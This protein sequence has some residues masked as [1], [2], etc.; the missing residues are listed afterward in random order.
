MSFIH[1]KKQRIQRPE[2]PVEVY[3]VP[4]V[5]LMSGQKKILIPNPAGSE[6]CVYPTLE[7][8]EE[9]V[10]RAGFDYVFEGK[11]TYALGRKTGKASATQQPEDILESAVPLLIERLQDREPSVLSNTAFALGELRAAEAAEAMVHLLGHE[12][13]GVRK[14]VAEALAK[15]GQVSIPI[16]RKAFS[17]AQRSYDKHATHV[18]LTVITAYL[19]MTH[20]HRELLEEVMP[21]VI[22]AL[23]DESWLVRAQAAL[24]VGQ[25]AQYLRPDK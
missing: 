13:G 23:K 1:I 24:V 7:E 18:R 19:A 15:L 17:D 6:A 12:E 5:A 9:A 20:S 16:L 11:K 25:S 4:A 14:E 22:E 10:M 2:G 8:A 21:Q 3:A